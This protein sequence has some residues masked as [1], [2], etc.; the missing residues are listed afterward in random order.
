MV[1]KILIKDETGIVLD[2]CGLSKWRSKMS[3]IHNT[4]AGGIIKVKAPVIN[5]LASQFRGKRKN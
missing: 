2:V 3:K 1:K 5:N 4:V